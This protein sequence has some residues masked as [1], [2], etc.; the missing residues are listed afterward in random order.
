[1]YPKSSVHLLLL[2]RNKTKNVQ[3]S[4][5]AFDDKDFLAEC[6]AECENVKR[7]VA[8]ELRRR[9]GKYSK[10]DQARNEAM[11]ADEPPSAD[12]LPPGRDWLKEVK[13][14]THTIPSMNHLHIHVFSKDM[15]S[16]PMRTASHYH[17][18]TTRFLIELDEF[19]LKANDPRRLSPSGATGSLECWRCGMGF[20]QIGKLKQHLEEEL[21]AWKRE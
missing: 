8:D 14:G 15:V 16:E 19:P 17:S 4:Q 2:P 9:Y 3:R 7:I 5:Q 1:M 13:A 11:D 20:G 10:Q 21:D 12:K 18:F 6:K